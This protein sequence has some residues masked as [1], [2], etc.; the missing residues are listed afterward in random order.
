MKKLNFIRNAIR[1]FFFSF[2]SLSL[3]LSTYYVLA[4]VSVPQED[5]TQNA[6]LASPPA[7]ADP[8]YLSGF[9]EDN[10]YTIFYEDRNDNVGCSNGARIYYVQTSNGAFGFSAPTRTNICDTHFVVKD[11]PVTIGGTTYAYRAWAA[12]GNNEDHNFYVSNDLVNWTRNPISGTS[13]TFND[14]NGTGL[15][16]YYGFHDVIQLNGNY[17]GFAETNGSR[18]LIVWSDEGTNDWDIIA[19][20]GGSGAGPLDLNVGSTGPTPTGNARP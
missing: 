9:G 13:F 19:V 1:F 6:P 4:E 8:R 20:V 11:M 16:V 14:P 2:I 12:V 3:A 5:Q 15:H 7:S 18:S 10:T 17:M